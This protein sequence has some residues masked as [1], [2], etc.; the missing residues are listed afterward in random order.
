MGNDS[1][2]DVEKKDLEQRKIEEM[3][4]HDALRTVT[5]DKRVTDTR[6]S[7]DEALGHKHGKQLSNCPILLNKK[8]INT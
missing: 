2:Q 8:E 1:S 3:K 5:D 4:F 7:P 6:W